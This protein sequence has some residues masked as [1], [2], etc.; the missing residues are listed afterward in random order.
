MF[1]MIGIVINVIIKIL[2]EEANVIDVKIK[3]IHNVNLI[4]MIYAHIVINNLKLN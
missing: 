2:R 3:E 4:K 1:C